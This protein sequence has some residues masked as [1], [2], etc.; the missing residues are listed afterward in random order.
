MTRFILI[1]LAAF[2]TTSVMIVAT[3]AQGSGLIG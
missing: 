1:S 2:G 3:A